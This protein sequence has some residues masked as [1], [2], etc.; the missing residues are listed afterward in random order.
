V[1][2]ILTYFFFRVYHRCH[3][4]KSTDQW[5]P[6]S[7]KY[8]PSTD[9]PPQT[10]P[11]TYIHHTG[12][13]IGQ[14][15]SSPPPHHGV[16]NNSNNHNG[17]NNKTQTEVKHEQSLVDKFLSIFTSSSTDVSSNVVSSP[18]PVAEAATATSKVAKNDL[19]LLPGFRVV[20]VTDKPQSTSGLYSYHE[21]NYNSNRLRN[22]FL[23]KRPSVY[24]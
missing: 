17:Q 11:M 5:R 9:G 6:C 20:D 24:V 12:P 23:M 14:T 19:D 3:V 15:P 21:N 18:E 16:N 4:G 13:P 1:W 7:D 10:W 22:R 2:R 8:F